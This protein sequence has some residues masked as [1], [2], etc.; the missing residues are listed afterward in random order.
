LGM[1][2]P[3]LSA[4]GSPDQ[5]IGA[6]TPVARLGAA[7]TGNLG[8]PEGRR[9]CTATLPSRRR[10][11]ANP[12]AIESEDGQQQSMALVARAEPEGNLG[13]ALPSQGPLGGDYQVGGVSPAAI[14]QREHGLA[15][16]FR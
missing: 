2:P 4:G 16:V 11:P 8:S 15:D 7:R 1:P 14:G 6:P 5:F 13:A 10:R 9:R 3:A 12:F